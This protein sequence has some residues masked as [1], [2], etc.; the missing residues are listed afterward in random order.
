MTEVADVQL[1]TIVGKLRE[2]APALRA[3]GVTRLYLFG[4]RARGD[5]RPHSDLDVL[6]ETTSREETPRFDYFRVLHL[7]ED[8]V[9][10]R[11]QLSMRDLLK[12]R[13]AERIADDLV[14]V[15]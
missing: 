4:S 13:V 8:Q 5:A 7:I 9:G 14:E 10:L 11:A 12:P 15:F 2:L 6:I 3:A 1:K